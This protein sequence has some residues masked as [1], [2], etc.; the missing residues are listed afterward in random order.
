[1]TAGFILKKLIATL[2]MPLPL[3]I[4]LMVLALILLLKRERRWAVGT[5]AGAIVWLSL[6]SYAPIANALLHPLESTYPPLL[7][8]PKNIEYI[9]V[10]G[11]GHKSD[12][13]L[14]LTSQVDDD[15]LIRLDE[16]IRLYHQL[17]EKP[18][19]IV[20]G[21]SGY[22]SDIPHAV[23]QKR[24]AVALGVDPEKIIM[25]SEPTD[26]EEEAAAAKNLIGDRP[27]ILV[28]SAYHMARAMR[29]FRKEG[30][31]PLPA[32]THHLSSEKE[33]AWLDIFSP[34]ALMN[35]TIYF[36]EKIG[37]LWQKIKSLL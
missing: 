7:Q 4:G 31:D 11:G 8:A 25:R 37:M 20:S 10:L 5:L 14:P 23:M 24:L 33:I 3:G 26:T 1:M 36:H 12:D 15:A 13:T 28:T 9:Y 21:Y 32:P 34:V 30:L 2:L 22:Y 16:A 29:W 35:T 17:N 19:I 27:F 18:E 6:F